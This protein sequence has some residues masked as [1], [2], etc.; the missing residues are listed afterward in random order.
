MEITREGD[1]LA[2]TRAAQGLLLGD[3]ARLDF[4]SGGDPDDVLDSEGIR[5][6]PGAENFHEI[7]RRD[8]PA[9]PAPQQNASG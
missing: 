9:A 1:Q 2:Q 7:A 3:R 4:D 8:R 5:R 6:L